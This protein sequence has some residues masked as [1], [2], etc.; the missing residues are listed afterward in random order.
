MCVCLTI[1]KFKAS[2]HP[3]PAGDSLSPNVF[4]K[5]DLLFG[6][7]VHG[8]TSINGEITSDQRFD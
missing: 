1:Q 4:R 2:I 6:T 3:S 8:I 5:Q 7:N